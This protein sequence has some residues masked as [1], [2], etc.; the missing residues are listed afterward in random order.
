MIDRHVDRKG[1]GVTGELPNKNCDYCLSGNAAAGSAALSGFVLKQ[2]T[3]EL[4]PP[5]VSCSKVTEEEI[6]IIILTSLLFTSC[7]C[8]GVSSSVHQVKF[9]HDASCLRRA[10]LVSSA[11][12]RW[13]LST[14]R[15][16]YLLAPPLS[17]G[18]NCSV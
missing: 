9:T 15:L 5:H 18:N 6:I 12:R 4:S 1:G 3:R 2:Q 7:L 16:L 13:A 11:C 17:G 8:V 10:H 14:C